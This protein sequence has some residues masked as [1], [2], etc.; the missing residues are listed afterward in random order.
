MNQIELLTHEAPV[1]HERTAPAPQ[2]GP[3][4][5]LGVEDG[6]LMRSIIAQLP[7]GSQHWV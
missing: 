3:Y 6:D 1:G 4:H 2:R 5:V 7:S